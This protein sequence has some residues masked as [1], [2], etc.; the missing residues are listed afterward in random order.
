MNHIDVIKARVFRHR[1]EARGFVWG[2]LGVGLFVNLISGGSTILS[3][4]VLPLI[5]FG[6]IVV[7]LELA[8]L[9]SRP[10]RTIIFQDSQVN[11]LRKIPPF[12]T[13]IRDSTEILILGGTLKTFTDDSA[14]L[15]ALS[16]FYRAFP[17]T[18][19]ILIMHPGGDGLKSTASARAARGNS[20][21]LQSLGAEVIHSLNRLQDSAGKTIL[22]NIR[23]YKEH[24]TY[25]MYKLGSAWILTVYTLGRGASSPAVYFHSVDDREEFAAAL[26]RG[27]TE[28]WEAS[29][30]QDVT[31]FLSERGTLNF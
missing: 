28:L 27:F 1:R 21:T 4:F 24:P 9:Y 13:L 20:D 23:V 29:T 22:K 6:I 17:N 16:T 7:F 10:S 8:I 30:T 31:E 15:D 11:L 3:R 25:S 19:R 12:A 5:I 2:A 14:A 26:E 18:L